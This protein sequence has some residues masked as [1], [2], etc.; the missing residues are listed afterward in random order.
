MATPK[1]PEPSQI[2]IDTYNVYFEKTA[3]ISDFSPERQKLI[4]SFYSTLA[5]RWETG[6]EGRITKMRDTLDVQ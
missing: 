3:L 4:R 1:K 2:E 5:I 6:D